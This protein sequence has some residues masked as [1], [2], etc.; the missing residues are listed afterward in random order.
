MSGILLVIAACGGGGGEEEPVPAAPTATPVPDPTLELVDITWASELD[1]STGEPVDEI[2]AFTTVSPAIIAVV[3][4]TDVPAGT[5]LTAG[6]TIDG[7]EV[8]DATMRVTVEQDMAVAWVAFEFIREEGRYFPLGELAV[9]V[10]TSTGESID[11]AVRIE[12]P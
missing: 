4:A 7:L 8:P 3:Q 12:L 1:R 9:T 2:D 5:E 11:G 6:W 10:T